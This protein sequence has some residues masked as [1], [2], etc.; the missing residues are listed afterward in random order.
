MRGL[1]G[2]LTSRQQKAVLSYRGPEG[3]GPGVRGIVYGPM[4]L[5]MND[6]EKEM[7]ADFFDGHICRKAPFWRRQPPRI[8]EVHNAPPNG[9]GPEWIARCACGEEI[10]IADVS[11]W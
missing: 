10:S 4:T 6:V 3:L 11:C 5:D 8:I 7:L 2:L 1:F 9:I